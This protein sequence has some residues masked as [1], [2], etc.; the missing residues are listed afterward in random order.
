MSA[1]DIWLLALLCGAVLC[2]V[3]SKVVA[4]RRRAFCRRALQEIS[5]RQA[6]MK[7]L[8]AECEAL[9]FSEAVARIYRLISVQ[10]THIAKLAENA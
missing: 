4:G 3:G 6:A 2:Y 5:E 8:R 10:E 9:G 7:R 1:T